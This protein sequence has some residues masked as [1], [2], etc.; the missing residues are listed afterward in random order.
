ML[1]R[2]QI[3]RMMNSCCSTRLAQPYFVLVRGTE[4][5]VPV[6]TRKNIRNTYKHLVNLI[7]CLGMPLSSRVH[8]FGSF[9][10]LKIHLL[11]HL[12]FLG[13]IKLFD[14]KNTQY[15]STQTSLL[16]LLDTSMAIQL[17]L[18]LKTHNNAS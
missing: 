2:T 1:K 4:Q 5:L 18:A 11:L 7:D 12:L 3:V 15:F 14:I 16:L 10:L 8:F 13:F 6:D 9:S 17:G